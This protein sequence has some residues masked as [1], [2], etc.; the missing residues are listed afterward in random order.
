MVYVFPD[1]VTLD[2]GFE[3]IDLTIEIHN[4]N[5]LPI[6]EEQTRLSIQQVRHHRTGNTIEQFWLVII[7][8][9]NL[10]ERGLFRFIIFQIIISDSF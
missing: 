2:Y 7:F 3:Y 1:D 6:I 10:C 4:F 8:I 9:E 5:N